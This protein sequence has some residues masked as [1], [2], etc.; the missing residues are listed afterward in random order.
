MIKALA[1]VAYPSDDVAGTRRWYEE[2][3]GLTFAGPYVED[4]IEKYNEAHLGDGCFSLLSSE[5]TGDDH[6]AGT[7]SRVVFEVDNLEAEIEALRARGVRVYGFFDGPVCDMVSIDDRR[8]QPHHAPPAKS[9]TVRTANSERRIQSVLRLL[10][11]AV[12][13]VTIASSPDPL[14]D[15]ATMGYQR[16]VDSAQI[17]ATGL[18]LTVLFRPSY[19]ETDSA[20]DGIPVLLLIRNTTDNPISIPNTC[21]GLSEGLKYTLRADGEDVPFHRDNGTYGLSHMSSTCGVSPHDDVS[22]I[23]HVARMFDVGSARTLT[24]TISGAP[25]SGVLSSLAPLDVPLS[26]VP[27]ASVPRG[28]PQPEDLS[29]MGYER[30]AL[31]PTMHGGTLQ[32]AVL[33][34]PMYA[35]TGPVSVVLLLRNLTSD[36]VTV[37]SNCFG[38][39]YYLTFTLRADGKELPY[40]PERVAWVL[41]HMSG[42]CT[43]VPFSSATFELPL[44]QAF[45]LGSG[46]RFIL[47]ISGGPNAHELTGLRMDVPIAIGQ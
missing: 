9:D 23:I 11:A 37:G 45:G 21:Y 24:L 46:R 29:T 4:G 6:K 35:R 13:A 10:T 38:I 44:D 34:H 40:H 43:I 2:T 26:I 15:Y 41:H 7:A 18:Q 8:R 16:H 30:I 31:S 36:P 1:F 33:T 28:G 32:L 17:G 5:W 14:L 22:F 39:F 3:L 12:A 20:S 19:S 47:D 25:R 27:T 42:L